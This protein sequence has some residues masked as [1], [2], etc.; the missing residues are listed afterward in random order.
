MTLDGLAIFKL[1]S[2]DNGESL[3]EETSSKI[4]KLYLKIIESSDINVKG[5][6]RQQLIFKEIGR[7]N[8]DKANHF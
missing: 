6:A 3:L 2:L 5:I 8:F 7:K 1:G 4:E